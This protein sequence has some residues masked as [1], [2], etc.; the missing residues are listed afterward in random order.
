MLCGNVVGMVSVHCC[1]SVATVMPH[2]DTLHVHV[3]VHAHV[4]VHVAVVP[5]D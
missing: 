3:H 2:V 5:I 1:S 4:H